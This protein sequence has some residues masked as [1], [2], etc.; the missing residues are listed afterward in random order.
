MATT[1]APVAPAAP[2]APA[3]APVAPT[4][5]VTPAIPKAQAASAPKPATP[6]LLATV[7]PRGTPTPPESLSQALSKVSREVFEPKPAAPAEPAAAVP[8]AP[9]AAAAVEAPPPSPP[10][11]LFADIKQ[12]DGM[13][14]KSLEGWK[15]LKAQASNK[16]AIAEKRYTDAIS[17]LDVLKKATPAEAADAARLKADLQAAHDRLAVLDV[18]SHPEHQR[19][20]AV[21][22]K[23]ALD[24]AQS[25]L[26]DNMVEGAPD[27][28]SLLT[29]SRNDFSKTISELA[30]KMPVYDQSSFTSSM[31]EAYRLHI[32]EKA[33][34]ATARELLPQLQAK[35]AQQ[36]RKAFEATWAEFDGKV[37]PL[38]MPDNATNEQRA[39]VQAYNEALAGIK[40]TAEK[41]AFGRLD[42]KGVADLAAK[43]AALD[44]MA[45]RAMPRMEREFA[46]ARNL[47]AELT[48]ELAAIKGKKNPGTFTG[49]TGEPAAVDTSKMSIP[50]LS[51]HMFGRGSGA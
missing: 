6:A 33:V 46:S 34:L 27:V 36:Q 11:D 49:P 28:A 47:I 20:F 12:P 25:L 2:A 4:K 24:D 44:F 41:N 14:E 19:K 35:S 50:E 48:A 16:I 1:P 38:P 22:Q 3:P 51:K 13:S 5:P 32:E 26:A 30:A 8:A 31:R 21:P 29:K 42:E 17:E 45:T 39:E 15:A 43:A 10:A 18:Q 40:T 7:T 23:R 9:A 37:K